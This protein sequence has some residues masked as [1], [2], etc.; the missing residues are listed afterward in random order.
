MKLAMKQLTAEQQALADYMSVLSEECWCAGW[1][2]GLEY[3]LWSIVQ[4]GTTYGQSWGQSEVSAVEMAE[5]KRLSELVGGWI[6]WNPGAPTVDDCPTFIPMDEWL[7][8]YEAYN[9]N[10]PGLEEL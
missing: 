10:G 7:K 4:S 3:A 2:T 9:K 8:K 6:F 5:L 1:L